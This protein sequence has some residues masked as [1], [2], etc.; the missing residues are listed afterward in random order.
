VVFKLDACDRQKSYLQERVK[1]YDLSAKEWSLQLE[2]VSREMPWLM[3]SALKLQKETVPTANWPDLWV[4]GYLTEA[5]ERRIPFTKMPPSW[6]RT[7]QLTDVSR[8]LQDGADTAAVTCHLAT[9]ESLEKADRLRSTRIDFPTSELKSPASCQLAD[10]PEQEEFP[11]ATD[12]QADR[13]TTED[14]HRDNLM[15]DTLTT[16]AHTH[17]TNNHSNCNQATGQDALRD[18]P[19]VEAKASVEVI[20]VD[21]SMVEDAQTGVEDLNKEASVANEVDL[22]GPLDS[23]LQLPDLVS[24]QFHWQ[25]ERPM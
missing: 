16:Q 6:H 20:K 3:P 22:V 15:T 23:R 12:Q 11:Q 17:G 2:T 7:I 8:E 1:P 13:R 4:L 10:Q 24:D 5:E 25:K 14:S 19:L 9:L 21:P 18:Q